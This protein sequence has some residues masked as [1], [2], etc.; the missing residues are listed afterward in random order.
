MI[1]LD[2]SV[3]IAHFDANDA[4]HQKARALL[5]KSGGEALG[6]S[7]MTLAETFVSPARAG[8]LEV[9]ESAVRQLGVEE[10]VI[11]AD[12]A[13]RLATL[14][15]G[16]KLKMPDCCVLLAAIDREAQLASFDESLVEAARGL[17]LKTAP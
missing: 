12:A 5:E 3:L 16:T 15:A 1:V 8:R 6:A 17:G 4:H 10:L 2:A 7:V 11:G 9:I 14:R 13:G